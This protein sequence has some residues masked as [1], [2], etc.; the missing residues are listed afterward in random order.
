MYKIHTFIE[1]ENYNAEELQEIL[2]NMCEK[3][4][5]RLSE[6]VRKSVKAFF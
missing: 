2:V 4:D 3:N 5:Y 6:E 1:F